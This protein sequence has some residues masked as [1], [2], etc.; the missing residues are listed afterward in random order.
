MLANLEIIENPKESVDRAY[1]ISIA[2]REELL[3]AYPTVNSFRR[4]V[5]AG[6]SVQ[7]LKKSIQKITLH[8]EYLHLQIIKLCS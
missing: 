6:I 2:A 1:D 4:N 8:L 3:V 5:S 7:L